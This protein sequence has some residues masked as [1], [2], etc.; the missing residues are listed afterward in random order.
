MFR[1]NLSRQK[2]QWLPPFPFLLSQAGD[3]ANSKASDFVPQVN[4]LYVISETD[5]AKGFI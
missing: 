4:Q 1:E 3:G 5:F 2:L